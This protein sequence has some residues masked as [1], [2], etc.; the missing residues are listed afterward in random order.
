MAQVIIVSNRLPISVK[1]VN[2]E[3]VFSPS[4]GGIATGLSSYVNDPGNTWIG[5]PGIASDDL[6]ESDKQKIATVLAENNCYPVFL[7]R[8][9]IDNFYNGFS[10][11]ILWPIFHNLPPSRIKQARL[12]SWWQ[13]YRKVNQKFSEA[14]INQ[15]EPKS[16][17]WVHDYQLM[18]LPGMLRDVN[19][20]TN[21]GFFLHIPFPEPKTFARVPDA[22]KL[23]NGILGSDLIGFHTSLYVQ[24]F[25][26]TAEAMGIGTV[27]DNAI[28][29]ADRSIRIGE[30][31]MGIDY[32][33][34]AAA[35]KSKQV[36]LAVK[37][38]KKRYRRRKVIVSVDRL[39]PTKGLEARLR[40]YDL[41]L[42][43]NP[44]QRGKI[45]FAMVAAPSRTDIMV[46]SHLAQRLKRIGR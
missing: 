31:P 2:A 11:S 26:S 19:T 9:Q 24:N 5:W 41:F 13:D 42:D 43:R 34:Y 30:F 7:S 39:D 46:Y 22:K 8:K 45:I 16:Q 28:T 10:N 23:L 35:S 44:S 3:L 38:Y 37:K 40:A 36:R 21:I 33:K 17:V 4:L 25:T 15:A 12:N 1:K 29:L 6:N 27:S 14:V 32:E 18:L 20:I